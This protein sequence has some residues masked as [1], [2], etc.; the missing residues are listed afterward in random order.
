MSLPL[1]S[2]SIIEGS[3]LRTTAETGEGRLVED[4]LQSFVASAHPFVVAALFAG[5]M[6]G[7]DQSS[8][9]GE[10]VCALESGEVSGTDQ[11]LGSE[12][13]SYSGKAS[14]DS[15]LLSGEKTLTDLPIEGLD[16]LLEGE[17]LC[18]D[19]SD[20]TGSELL[21][22]RQGDALGFSRLYRLPGEDV[23]SFDGAVFQEGW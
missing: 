1:S 17:H 3:G 11:E 4:V 23:C 10:L 16:G 8:I 21:G 22:G 12:G 6:G 18:G 20:D 9:G 5:F 13:Y 14:E 2:F 19:L 15:R 7:G